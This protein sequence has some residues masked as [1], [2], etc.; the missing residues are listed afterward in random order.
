[1]TTTDV[2]FLGAGKPISGGNP[3]ALKEIDLNSCALDWQLHSLESIDLKKIYFLGGYQ[4][5][6]I[7][8]RYPNLHY[9]VVPDWNIKPI[10]YTLSQAKLRK[11]PTLI[12]YADT[13]FRKETI[14]QVTRSEADVTILCDSHWELRYNSREKED[15]L[16]A[17]TLLLV[18]RQYCEQTSNKFLD[19]T[20]VEFTGVIKLSPSVAEFVSSLEEYKVGSSLLDLI[21]YLFHQG[22]QIKVL[23][24]KGEWTEFNSP[25][26]ITRF[27]LGTKAETLARLAPL[28]TNCYIGDQVCFTTLEWKTKRKEIISI[29]KKKFLD[30]KLVVRS[31]GKEE[32]TWNASKAGWF[33]S[34]INID[35]NSNVAITEAVDCVIASYGDLCSEKQDQILIQKFIKD[36]AFS[37]VVFTCIL[38][39]GAPYYRINFDDKTTSTESIT[40]GTEADIRTVLVKRESDHYLKTIDKKLLPVLD[41]IQEL[42]RL[43]GFHKLDVEF[44]VDKSGIVHIFQVRPIAVNHSNFETDKSVFDASILNSSQDFQRFQT[45]TPFVLGTKTFFGNMP[46][47]NPAEIIGIRPSPLAIS[48]YRWLITDEVWAKQRTEFGYRDVRPNPLIVCFCGQPYVDIRASLNSFIPAELSEKTAEKFVD[49]YLEILLNNPSLHDKLEF[50]IALTAWTPSFKRDAINRLTPHQINQNQIDEME[51][52]LKL[53][54]RK[55]ILRLDKDI[56]PI[57]SLIIRRDLLENS[58]LSPIDKA[59]AL[60]DDCRRFGSLAFAHAARAGFIAKSFLKSFVSLDILTKADTQAFLKTIKTIASE[61]EADGKRVSNGELSKEAYLERYGHLRP[62]TY[63]ITVE[64]YWEMPD[65]Y[66]FSSLKSSVC[67]RDKV[68]DFQFS[69]VTRNE[70]EFKF[71][72]IDKDLTFDLIINYIREAIQAREYLKFEFTRNVSRALDL[73]VKHGLALELSRKDIAFLGINEFEQLKVGFLSKQNLTPLIKQRKKNYTIT[74]MI[75]LPQLLFQESDFYCFERHA[76]QPNFI[77]DKRI[78]AEV[79]SCEKGKNLDP[80]EKIVLISQADPGYDWLLMNNI[81]GLIT[82]YGGANSHMAIRA[83]EMS[84]PAAIGIG[85]K[86]YEQL[87]NAKR[88][89]LDCANQIIR[90]IT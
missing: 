58:A 85:D 33:N 57:K 14:A 30:T 42:E 77:T 80:N 49:A 38:E 70:I 79:I 69:R 3:A 27:L 43:L 41:A 10:L 46:D 34:V 65:K 39:T 48:L 81:K 72:T 89:Q 53:I 63:D 28:V 66:L 67:E 54:T 45:K 36:V 88:I 78:E 32:D 31:S 15:L 24:V 50:D 35:G 20:K 83:A 51:H 73:F 21:D 75:E 74:Q 40:L 4:I 82:K 90:Q 23:D 22:Y 71:K 87:L 8:E 86:L 56:E 44:A 61:F 1:M 16:I 12:T 59:M 5:E 6:K 26:D 84:L 7:I 62:G 13:I 29:I 55:S 17:E 68:S 25:H 19:S 64:A 60:L 37:G 11:V 52:A 2:F 47:W 76:S 9:T 18:D